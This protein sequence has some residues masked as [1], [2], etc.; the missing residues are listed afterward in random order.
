M[1]GKTYNTALYIRLSREDGDNLESESITN[2]REI[3]QS[4]LEKTEEKLQ[5]VDEYVDDGFTGSNFDRPAWQKLLTDIENKKIN[6]IITKDLSRMGRDYISM[7]EY[8]E[9]IFPERGIRYIA[10]NDDIDTLYETPGLD[11]LQFKLVFNDYFL[12]D[13]SKKIRKVLKSKKESGKFLGWKAVYGYI[14]DPDD[15]HK[16]LVDENV[17]HII[18]RMFNL[19]IEG[20]SPRQIAD[21]FSKEKIPTPS[22]YASLNR[23]IKST[24]YELWCPRTIEEMLINETYIGNL[25]QGRR[26]KLNYKSKKEVRTQK[27]DW[28]ISKN[29]HEAIIDKKT[30]KTVQELLKKN[31]NK[32]NSKNLCLLSGFMFCKECG[33]AIGINKSS[34]GKRQYCVCTYYSAHSKFGLCTPHSNNYEKLEYAVLENIKGMCKEYVDATTFKSKV[35]EAQKRNDLKT[36]KQKAINLLNNRIKSSLVYIDKIYEDKLKGNIDIEM[37]N[38][39]SLKYKDEIEQFKS[40]IKELEKEISKLDSEESTKEKQDIL[41]KINEYLSFENPNRNLLVNL[42]DKILISEDKTVEIHYKFRVN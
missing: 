15:K 33:H 37:F 28:I 38:R 42:I 3:L 35:E 14:K 36:K 18:E 26:K 29:T 2:Q 40:Q 27:E 8:I 11:F 10:L 41:K 6:T 12:K 1:K 22:V 19:V 17:K 25:T 9:R 30:F 34:D 21:I 4:Y 31:K 5:Y 39:S 13:T 32:A 24:A 23:G 16:L 20:E 7:G